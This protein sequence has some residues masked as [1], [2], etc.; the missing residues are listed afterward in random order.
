MKF[1]IYSHAYIYQPTDGGLTVL[2]TIAKM[3]NERGHDSKVFLPSKVGFENNT[4]YTN[5]HENYTVDADTIVIY[6]DCT[7]GNPM[8]ATRVV[9]WIGYGSHWYP[10][11]DT[12]EVV[13]YHAPFCKEHIPTK[14]LSI[15]YIHPAVKNMGLPRTNNSCFIVKKGNYDPSIRAI[16]SDPNIFSKIEGVNIQDIRSIEE[17][18]QIFNTTK[19][20]FCYDPCSFLV[21][22]AVLCGCVVI[23]HPPNGYIEKEWQYAC[24]LGEIP[25]IAYGYE[26]LAR[27][28]LTIS[29]APA[30]CMELLKASEI[31]MDKFVEDMETSNYTNAPCFK[32]NE[33]PFSFQF[34]DR[35][36]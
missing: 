27:A 30:K 9:R 6:I 5:Y 35:R 15:H 7:I 1:V 22:V 36:I 32:F 14:R 21:I 13:Y 33:S 3:L 2:L 26:N 16:F 18:V 10:D 28:E 23:Q 25:G 4:L 11:Y 20:F 17:V 34:I 29:D 19:Y 31:Y 8:K 24:G 12:N